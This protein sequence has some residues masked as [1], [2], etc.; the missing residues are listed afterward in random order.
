[1]K[2]YTLTPDCTAGFC[3]VET[4]LNL[5]SGKWKGIILYRLVGG[6]KRFNELKKIMP[7]I[8]YRTLTL[9]LRQ[10]EEDGIVERVA[11]PEV[12]PRVEY[13]LT[14]LGITMI[15]IIEALYDWGMAY[16]NNELV[17]SQQVD[18]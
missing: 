16:H 14:P 3:P 5:V 2:H 7:A 1:M 15:P 12:P 4:T 9:Q 13:S 8:S 6:K 17:I 11:Y 18:K 10:L